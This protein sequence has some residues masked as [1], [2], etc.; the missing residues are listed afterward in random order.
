[1]RISENGRE[2]G[3]K[4]AMGKIG[5]AVISKVMRKNSHA[6][7][8]IQVGSSEQ[9][10][11]R[12]KAMTR[13]CRIALLAALVFRVQQAFPCSWAIGYFH[14]VIHLRGTLVGM[15]SHG[16]PRWIRQRAT[17]SNVKLSLFECRWPLHDWKERP[18]VKTV[19]TDRDGEFDFG[20]VK[21]GHYTLVIDWPVAHGD[22]F[23]VEI[24]GLPRPTKS[25]TIDVSP[26][27]PD[28]S[29]GHE[30]IALSE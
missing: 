25:V 13:F 14:Q 26:V 20:S 6:E 19:Q 7:R 15:D 24:R 22:S 28:C 11:A 23:D 17:R 4:G 29:G 27:Y 10:L 21:D 12:M 2:G 3:V 8:S 9:G 30:F 18:L 5:L 1:M 16:W